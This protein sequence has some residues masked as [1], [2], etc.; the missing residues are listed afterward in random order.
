M[1]NTSAPEQKQDGSGQRLPAGPFHVLGGGCNQDAIVHS[2]Q[3]VLRVCVPPGTGLVYFI[4]PC[5]RERVCVC[6]GVGVLRGR[7]VRACLS[8]VA[9]AFPQTS[10]A[11]ATPVSRLPRAHAHAR[12]VALR[13]TRTRRR[14]LGRTCACTLHTGHAHVS[15]GPGERLFRPNK[16]AAES[17]QACRRSKFGV[18]SSSTLSTCRFGPSASGLFDLQTRARAPAGGCP[19]NQTFPHPTA[20]IHHG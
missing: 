4:G 17:P 16:S 20:T 2:N 14:V 18:W 15:S 9:W 7:V 13:I 6:V 3:G 8:A 11:T 12:C 19:H 5:M 1:R 10:Y